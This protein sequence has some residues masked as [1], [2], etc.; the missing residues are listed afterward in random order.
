MTYEVHIGFLWADLLWV[1]LQPPPATDNT[2]TICV[3]TCNNNLLAAVLSASH[4]HDTSFLFHPGDESVNKVA[5]LLP[6]QRRQ[7]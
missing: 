1:T 7:N 2:V 4:L 3:T 6:F 5:S